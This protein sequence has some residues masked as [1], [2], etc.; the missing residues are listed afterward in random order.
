MASPTLTIVIPVYNEEFD[1]AQCLWSIAKQTVAPDEVIVVDNNSSDNSVKI[2]KKF[3]FVRVI[4]EP[5]QGIAYARNA[6]FDAAKS[7]I[8]GR[9][10]ADSRLSPS[11]VSAVKRY[12]SFETNLA[13]G[14]SGQGYFYNTIWPKFAGK[15]QHSFAFK[16]NKLILGNYILWGSNMAVP[17]YLWDIVKSDTCF[18]RN[19]HEDIDLAI[20]LSRMGFQINHRKSMVVGVKMKR[21]M[22]DRSSLWSNLMMWPRTFWMHHYQLWFLA[23]FGAIFLYIMSFPVRLTDYFRIY[24]LNKPKRTRNF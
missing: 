20:H 3:K 13:T 10:D 24:A 6:G 14:V 1:I 15:I 18:Q 12:Y 19:I 7:Q 9:I 22:N 17:K 11:W 21:V 8:I 16:Y 4:H 2:A 5:N 23:G